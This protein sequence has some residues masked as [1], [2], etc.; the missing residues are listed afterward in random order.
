MKTPSRARKAQRGV[1]LIVSL[2]LL[3][4][5][6]IG[7]LSN[8]RTIA[9]NEKM[10]SAAYDRGIAFQAAEA[11]LR[12]GEDLVWNNHE[13]PAYTPVYVDSDA[14]CPGAVAIN[15][16]LAGVCPAP[17]KDCTPRWEIDVNGFSGWVDAT[18]NLGSLAGTRPQYFIEYLGDAFVCDPGNPAQKCKR[19]R[20]TARSNPGVGRS[21][22]VLQSILKT[23]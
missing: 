15:N 7:G 21:T 1:A 11:A 13:D 14:V 23:E 18:T 22:V 2:I 9:L 16:C 12:F 5:I 6:T 19:Y 3:V 10:T 17:D 20:V 4:I 8:V